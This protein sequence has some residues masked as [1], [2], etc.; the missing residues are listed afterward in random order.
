[1]S[2]K[3]HIIFETAKIY[4]IKTLKSYPRLLSVASQL[5]DSQSITLKVLFRGPAKGD[6]PY[7]RG[8]TA[9]PWG[10]DLSIFSAAL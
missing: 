1:L 9:Y 4:L 5:A 10:G 2:A 7:S 6:I 8:A 3:L